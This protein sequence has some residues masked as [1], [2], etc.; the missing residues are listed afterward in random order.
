MNASEK[1]LRQLFFEREADYLAFALKYDVRI[2]ESS[3]AFSSFT[4]RV[5]IHQSDGSLAYFP[6]VPNLI[7]SYD[8]WDRVDRE[9]NTIESIPGGGRICW[10]HKAKVAKPKKRHADICLDDYELHRFVRHGPALLEVTVPNGIATESYWVRGKR[11]QPPK[12]K[13]AT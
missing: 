8:G 9:G 6:N 1:A 5:S 12:S 2:V 3:D 7:Y 13:K 10:F 4:E 11:V